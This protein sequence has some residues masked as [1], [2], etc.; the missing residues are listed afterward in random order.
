MEKSGVI[1]ICL[2]FSLAIFVAGV[3]IGASDIEGRMVFEAL[4]SILTGDL[5]GTHSSNIAT[6][7]LW[8]IRLPRMVAAAVVGSCLAG[9]GVLSQGL[10]RN[11]LASPSVLGA[12]SG[13]GALSALM[14]YFGGVYY[15]WLTLPFAGVA[16]AFLATMIILA[17]ASL[18]SFISIEYLLLVGFALNAL[19]GAVTSLI[20]SLTL[21][22]Y[23][24]SQ[25]LMH[26][27]LGSL[28]AASWDH[29]LLGIPLLVLG[30]IFSHRVC[31]ELDV[32]TFGEEVAKTLSVDVVRL[33]YFAIVC[34]AL[35]VGVSVAICGAVAFV[36]LIVPHLTRLMVG[37]KH[38]RL[39]VVSAING[40]TLV[41]AADLISRTIIAP[42][43]LQV[44]VLIAMIGAP[45]FILLLWK[46]GLNNA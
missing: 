30:F 3:F 32:L 46:R 26:W 16:G 33:K 14:F 44:G 43:E 19:L 34:I 6:A 4:Y 11:P 20:V 15:H 24:R 12:T 21:A 38:R 2:L 45:F 35:L 17:V 10:F 31:R 29:L 13:A 39:F 18:R 22:D 27:L 41:M 28:A 42:R 1:F 25:A 36:G 7:I 8:E 40:A 23:Q 37:M 5:P 9:A